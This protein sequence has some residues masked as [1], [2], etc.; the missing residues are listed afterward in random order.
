MI[1]HTTRDNMK[2]S[3]LQDQAKAYCKI[4]KKQHILAE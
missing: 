4:I 2:Y 3:I 1:R